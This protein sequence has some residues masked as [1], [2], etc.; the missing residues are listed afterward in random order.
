MGWNPARSLCAGANVLKNRVRQAAELHGGGQ[1]WVCK[2][3]GIHLNP[4]TSCPRDPRFPE[5]LKSNLTRNPHRTLD[6]SFPCPQARRGVPSKHTCP[7]GTQHHHHPFAI[8][9]QPP[10]LFSLHGTSLR[11]LVFVG[12]PSIGCPFRHC[13][14]LFEN[15]CFLLVSPTPDPLTSNLLLAILKPITE[16]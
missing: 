7:R 11:Q 5:P 6:S 14:G 12:A 10:S 15:P 8:A 4:Q 16:L 3:C 13:R 2:V 1:A 9:T